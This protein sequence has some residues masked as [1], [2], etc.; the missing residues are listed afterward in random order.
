MS[1]EQQIADYIASQPE[2]KRTDMQ[3][4]H[5]NILAL[6][7]GGRLWFYDGLNETKKV[8]SNPTIGYGHLNLKYADDSS[9]EY[10]RIGLLANSTGISVHILGIEDKTYLPRTYA[11]TLG[12]ATITGYCIRFKKLKDIDLDVLLSAVQYGIELGDN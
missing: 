5:D 2:A 7:P 1:V 3:R 8:I 10:F 11:E 12:K 6:L 9:R 4:I